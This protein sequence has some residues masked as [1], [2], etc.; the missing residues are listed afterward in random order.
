MSQSHRNSGAGHNTRV[1]LT[2]TDDTGP[3]QLVAMTG[4]DG[5]QIGEA[6]RS[7]HFGFTSHAPAGAEGLALMLGGGADRVHAL[8]LEHPQYRPRNLPEGSSR[9]Y[10]AF[11]NYVD[12]SN[13]AITIVHASKIVLQVGGVSFTLTSSGIV[14]SGGSITHDGKHIDKTHVHTDAGGVGDSGPPA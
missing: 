14:V 3:Q 4:L 12:L 7:Q 13:G 8:G 10:D 2:Q 6:V 1:S 9:Q 11:G 5:Q